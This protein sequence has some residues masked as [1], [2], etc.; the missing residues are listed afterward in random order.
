MKTILAAL[1]LAVSL[2]AA[3]QT[4]IVPPAEAQKTA[5]GLITQQ[6]T[7]GT[8]TV[9]PT[10]DSVLRL[11]YTLSTSEGKLLQKIEAPREVMLP[12]TKM[13]PG[14]REAAAM[15]VEGET[16]RAWVTE[17]LGAKGQVPA[18]GSLVIDTNLLEIIPGPKT[19]EDVAAPP[20]DAIVKKNGLAYK[21]LREG[22]GRKH[23]S[24]R[25]NV[26]VHYSGWTT[27]GKLFDSSV[28]RGESANFPMTGVIPGWQQVL[29]EMVEGERVRVWVP[30][31][32]AYSGAKGKPKGTLVFDIELLS[33]D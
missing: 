20:A 6:L 2:T 21:I 12:M 29:A 30:E 19:P 26:T 14:W 18:G 13:I 1:S 5:S 15:M 16:R 8:G 31:R 33:A 25:G 10:D 4:P 11:R 17:A 32:L 7:A 23:P 27:D 24:Y 22:T 9:H 3:A 28:A